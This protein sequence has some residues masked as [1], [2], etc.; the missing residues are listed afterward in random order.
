M[1]VLGIQWAVV[2]GIVGIWAALTS[3]GAVSAAIL[4]TVPAT[5][6]ALWSILTGSAGLHDMGVTG[7]ELLGAFVIPAP[8]AIAL[9]FGLSEVRRAHDNSGAVVDDVLSS[10]LA[11]PKFV[12]LP[13]LIVILGVSYWEKVV[14]A[15]GDGLIVVIIG[16]AAASYTAEP[17]VRVMARALRMTR[18]QFFRKVYLPGALPVIVQ[19]LHLSVILTLGALLLAEE[20]ISSSGMGYLIF[21]AGARAELD[22]LFGGIIVVAVCAVIINS[23]FQAAENRMYRWHRVPADTA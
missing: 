14:Y 11:T 18:R 13:V 16:T 12:F 4:P 20:Y 15:L 10:L 5:A 1:G 23:G 21:Q 7:L 9:G 8:A 19:A 2:A 22:K 6:S 3:S 17:S